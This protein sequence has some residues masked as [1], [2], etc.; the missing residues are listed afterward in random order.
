MLAAKVSAT[1]MAGLFPQSAAAD[2]SPI[3]NATI[4]PYR[5]R[6]KGHEPSIPNTSNCNLQSGEQLRKPWQDNCPA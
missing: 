6:R 5:L 2:Q 3:M 4:I 1:L